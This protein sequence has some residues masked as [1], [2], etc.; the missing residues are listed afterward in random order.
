[1]FSREKRRACSDSKSNNDQLFRFRTLT[2]CKL[3]S[4]IWLGIFVVCNF[5][6]LGMVDIQL[7]VA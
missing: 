4:D 2:S 6:Y 5:S 3:I 1:M 7:L